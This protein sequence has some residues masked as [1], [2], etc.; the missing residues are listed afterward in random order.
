MPQHEDFATPE[1]LRTLL[2]KDLNELLGQPSGHRAP[3]ACFEQIRLLLEALPLDTT[4]FGLA[5][6]RL[7]NARHYL[8]SGEYGAARYELHLLRRSLE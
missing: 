4:E 8:E 7:A 1:A 6:N 3:A 2:C 5:L